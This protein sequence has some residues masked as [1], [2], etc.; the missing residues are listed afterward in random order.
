MPATTQELIAKQGA[1]IEKLVQEISEIEIGLEH[2][3]EAVQRDSTE[4][5]IGAEEDTTLLDRF[6]EIHTLRRRNRARRRLLQ[7]ER[8]VYDTLRRGG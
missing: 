6:E 5:W 7:I 1:R 3:D 4:S 8:L 2:L